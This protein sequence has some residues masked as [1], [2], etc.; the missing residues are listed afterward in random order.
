M[1][2]TVGQLRWR[3]GTGRRPPPGSRRQPATWHSSPCRSRASRALPAGVS[4]DFSASTTTG[5]GCPSSQGV[6]SRRQLSSQWGYRHS[7][8]QQRIRLVDNVVRG[9]ELDAVP[10]QP[11]VKEANFGVPRFPSIKE[12][13]PTSGVHEHRS[14]HERGYVDR[15][16]P[17][18]FRHSHPPRQYGKP[19]VGPWA[20]HL[21]DSF[22]VIL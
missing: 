16:D 12:A 5:S 11:L 8:E 1:D 19:G 2:W 17:R 20:R 15:T 10:R 6:S 9:H 13:D 14:R 21:I 4:P 18:R 3:W 7:L 22:A